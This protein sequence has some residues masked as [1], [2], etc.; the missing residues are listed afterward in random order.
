MKKEMAESWQYDT[1]GKNQ[2]GFVFLG[3]IRNQ[4]HKYDSV[5]NSVLREGLNNKVVFY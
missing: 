5:S 3:G 2:L 4:E 1:K